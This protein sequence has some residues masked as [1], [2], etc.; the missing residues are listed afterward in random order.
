MSTEKYFFCH[1]Q[2]TGG[3]ALWR[4]LQHHFGP[5]GVYP[6]PDDGAPPRNTTSVDHLLEVW[7]RRADEIQVVCGHFPLCTTEL[8]GGSFRTF[9]VLRDPVER[10][11]SNL[12]HR[13]QR[14]GSP[15]QPLAEFYDPL[16]VALLL[17]NHMTRML[18]LEPGELDDEAMLTQIDDD[19]ARLQTAIDAL[20]SIDIVG[21][22]HDF[23]A[24]CSR[25]ESTFGWDL[26][27]RLRM[28]TSTGDHRIDD[29]LRV[30]I[31]DDTRRDRVLYAHALATRVP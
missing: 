18:S 31:E 6:G 14:E 16:Y 13:R 21:F 19:E 29:D 1:L 11:I 20:D 23:D 4:R 26:G 24:L 28:N 3:T 9:T 7:E 30:R 10:V 22:Q 8:L 5:D 27:E 17:R 2:K 25:L 15:E 12:R